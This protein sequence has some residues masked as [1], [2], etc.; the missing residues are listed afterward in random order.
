[1]KKQKKSNKQS[2]QIQQKK[3]QLQ[4]QSQKTTQCAPAHRVNLVKY[5]ESLIHTGNKLKTDNNGII[6][7]EGSLE[8]AELVFFDLHGNQMTEKDCGN[9][10]PFVKM[11][12]QGVLSQYFL[13]F[14]EHGNMVNPYD[15]SDMEMV[16]NGLVVW[17][18]VNKY[19]YLTYLEFLHSRKDSFYVLSKSNFQV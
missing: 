12:Q 8:G 18:K 15:A 10:Q 3:S 2:K 1:M 9:K 13:L 19:S 5:Q 7:K 14:T 17:R 4:P 16:T 6:C 11:L